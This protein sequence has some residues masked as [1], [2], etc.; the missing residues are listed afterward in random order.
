MHN[1]TSILVLGIGNVLWADEGFGVRV[2]ETLHR[3]YRFPEHVQVVDGGTQGL[4]LLGHVRAATHI[5]VID[6]VD[7][8]L[9][10]GTLKVVRNDEVPA[11]LG[12]GKMSM[13]QLG[14]QEVLACAQMLGEYPREL[15]LIGVQPVELED[16]GGSLRDRVRAQI[17][18]AMVLALEQLAS[19]G[20]RAEHRDGEISQAERIS[21]Q[22]IEM[23]GYE[24]GR[25]SAEVACRYGDPRFL[26]HRGGR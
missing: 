14:F 6:A 7:Y 8:R 18:P 17:E 23:S 11:Y 22:G 13:H 3:R 4:Y 20:A 16:F 25:P 19:W 15:V 5:I 24:E 10:P 9:A 21:P 1:D 26:R 12:A 2:I